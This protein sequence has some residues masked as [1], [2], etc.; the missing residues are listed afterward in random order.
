MDPTGI[1]LSVSESDSKRKSHLSVSLPGLEAWL[2][3]L[4]ADGVGEA[5][6]M[7]DE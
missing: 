4:N 5:D 3:S 7:L 2:A 1:V 6:D